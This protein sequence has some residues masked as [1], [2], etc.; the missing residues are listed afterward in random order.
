M[1]SLLAVARRAVCC[2]PC[3]DRPALHR[4]SP[5]ASSPHSYGELD[6]T[7]QS[8]RTRRP[9]QRR[10]CPVLASATIPSICEARNTV[11]DE[12]SSVVRR[13]CCASR[14]THSNTPPS[15]QVCMRATAASATMAI[16]VRLLMSMSAGRT[17]GGEALVSGER[18]VHST[19]PRRGGS[20]AEHSA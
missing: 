18:K 4:A 20:F 13:D 12:I 3:P 17:V 16:V 1:S 7:N 11:Q 5:G 14:N 10:P 6:W 2:Q 19:T 15:Y 9:I 8:C